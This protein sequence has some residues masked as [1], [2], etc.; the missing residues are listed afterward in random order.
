LR[1]NNAIGSLNRSWVRIRARITSGVIRMGFK[2]AAGGFVEA[3]AALSTG[4]DSSKG[5][6]IPLD[7]AAQQCLEIPPGS[8]FR[9][10]AHCAGTGLGTRIPDEVPSLSAFGVS[11]TVTM[12]TVTTTET[13]AN[14]EGSVEFDITPRGWSGAEAGTPGFL[15]LSGGGGAVLSVGA[16]GT[17]VVNGMDTTV[18]PADGV[19]HRI[20]FR[21][22]TGS[23]MSA[24]VRD[25]TGTLL[26]ARVSAAYGGALP[27]AG[28]WQLANNGGAASIKDFQTKR[29]GGG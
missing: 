10:I 12:G 14:R 8:D 3:V 19:T 21:W 13:P 26:A 17:W 23:G 4:Y 9:F 28:V 18:A 22:K 1:L 5:T 16:G 24:E 20:R 15:Y 2:T 25:T 27:A 11:S 6:A 29:N 7:V